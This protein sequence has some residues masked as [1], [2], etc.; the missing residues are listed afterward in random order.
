M[1]GR[2]TSKP[3]SLSELGFIGCGWWVDLASLAPNPPT[4]LALDPL[5]LLGGE[6]DSKSKYEFGE[7]RSLD[8]GGDKLVDTMSIVGDVLKWFAITNNF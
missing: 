4:Q 6:G 1:R 2:G 5:P 3:K 8:P 7:A